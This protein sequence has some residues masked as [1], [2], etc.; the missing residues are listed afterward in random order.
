MC[1][2]FVL[3]T[4]LSAIA[5]DFIV[6]DISVNFSAS[7]NVCPGDQIPAIVRRGDHNALALFQ[8][9]L[10]PYWCKDPSIGARLFN[11]RAETLL[12]KPSFKNAFI[13]RRC[14]IPADGFFEWK[15]EG[16]KKIPYYFFLKSEKPM[17]FAGLYETW[18]APDQ[19]P[20]NS[21]T[22]ITVQ[23]NAVVEP[24]HDR[25]PVIVP[26]NVQ[27]LWLNPAIKDP[28]RLL[29]I[30]KP[31]PADELGCKPADNCLGMSAGPSS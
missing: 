19:K 30:L 18:M 27:D 26:P 21:C 12:E 17:V 2:R 25:M 10:I 6:S 9:G 15:K 24:I 1:G 22:I 8:W 5:R 28:S 3:I 11:A 29:D 13:N 7:R 20:V 23:P 4:D 14:L 31:Y 16:D